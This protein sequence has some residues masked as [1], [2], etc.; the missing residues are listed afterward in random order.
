MPYKTALSRAPAQFSAHPAAAPTTE[1]CNNHSA[2]RSNQRQ[3]LCAE[4]DRFRG[5]SYFTIGTSA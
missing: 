5:I 3:V 1:I 4:N 2:L